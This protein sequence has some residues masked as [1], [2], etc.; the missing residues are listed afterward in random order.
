[1]TI[2][3]IGITLLLAYVLFTQL[4]DFCVVCIAT[5]ICN[6]AVLNLSYQAAYGAYPNL[7][8]KAA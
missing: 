1:M 3:V 5:Y 4:Q 6:F 2:P 8:K 7:N